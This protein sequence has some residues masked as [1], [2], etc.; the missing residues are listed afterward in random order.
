[1]LILI[2]TYGRSDRQITW[3]NLPE[4]I[5]ART[6]LVVQEREKHLY[7]NRSDIG[8]YVALPDQIRGIHTTRQ[9]LI[10]R[11][12]P[13]PICMLDDDLEFAVRRTDEPTKF[14]SALGSEIS[15][16]IH[17]LQMELEVYPLV[18]VA[19]RE[20]ANRNT[21]DYMQATRQV[22]VHAIDTE[23]FRKNNIRF[24]RLPFMGDF[25]M[26]LQVLATG[27]PNLVLN[28]YVTNQ[29]GS[30]TAGGCSETRTKEGLETA[31]KG[32][33]ALWPKYVQ[34]VRKT[35]KT[36]WG[37]GERV[38]VRVQWKRCY[39]DACRMLSDESRRSQSDLGQDD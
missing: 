28:Q 25:D 30:N 15:D 26:T 14:R 5:Q 23:F 17:E 39:E 8:R 29:G 20:G 22:R 7:A 12:Y 2:P 19:V 10:D 13:Q 21:D 1:M 9:Y 4:D 24:D 31:A 38:D 36:S 37:G 33:A 11:L 16:M 3:E 35:T 32:L 6:I 27:N 34:L 18:G